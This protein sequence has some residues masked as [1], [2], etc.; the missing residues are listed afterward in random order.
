M[1]FVRARTCQ[2]ARARRPGHKLWVTA[3]DTDCQ[4][5][6]FLTRIAQAAGPRRTLH[7][8]FSRGGCDGGLR[9]VPF[10]QLS[11]P[12]P[13]SITR[14]I[15]RGLLLHRECESL[16][17]G[18]PRFAL[19]M[20]STG[21]TSRSLCTHSVGSPEIPARVGDE[22]T[23]G[24]MVDGLNRRDPL[25]ELGVVAVDVLYQ[26]GLR[27]CLARGPEFAGGAAFTRPLPKKSVSFRGV[28]PPPP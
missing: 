12:N 17:L 16:R 14:Q 24:G 11:E 13:R 21:P 18:P 15:S 6:R 8:T 26:F 5:V 3:D 28:A 20:K 27:L 2:A 23:I 10:W 9:L 7:P 19:S 25:D 22:C 1:P 4:R